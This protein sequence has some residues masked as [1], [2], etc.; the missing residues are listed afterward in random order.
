MTQ[1]LI[2]GGTGSIGQ[3]LVLAFRRHDYDVVFQYHTQTEVAKHLETISGAHGYQADF[4][5]GFAKLPTSEIDVLINGA[6]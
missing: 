1:V 4:S 3:Q 6:V 2:T 5:S